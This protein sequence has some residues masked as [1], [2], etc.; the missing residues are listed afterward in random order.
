MKIIKRERRAEKN[1]KGAIIVDTCCVHTLP[2]M[3]IYALD[4]PVFKHAYIS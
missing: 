3:A 2:F 4:A 1:N